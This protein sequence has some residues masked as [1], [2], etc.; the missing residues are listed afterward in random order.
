MESE[1]QKILYFHGFA[2]SGASG[3]AQLLRRALPDFE[4]IAPD[5]P[6]DPRE[7]LPFLKNLCDKE[8]PDLIL[9]SSMGGMYAQQM[10]GHL[11][12]LSNPAFWMSRMSK[13]MKIGTFNYLN[14]RKDKQMQGRV[15][16]EIMNAFREMEDHQFDGITPEDEPLCHAMFGRHDPLARGYESFVEHYPESQAAW[17]DGEHRINDYVMKQTI[18]PK[19][20][21]MLYL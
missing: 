18:L 11:R 13:V 6:L 16:K 4:I 19:I 2:S 12:L 8:Q 7:A 9:G 17:F 5:I 1:K 21:E 15:T 20:K 3:T 10:R 14:K